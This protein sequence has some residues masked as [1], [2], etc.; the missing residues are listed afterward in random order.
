M[1]YTSFMDVSF[2]PSG[3]PG[4][5]D[6]ARRANVRLQALKMFGFYSQTPNSIAHPE[7]V[8]DGANSHVKAVISPTTTPVD[9]GYA[10]YA[11]M[12]AATPANGTR[13][14]CSDPDPLLR[15]R[16]QR[17]TGTWT[18]LGD[19]TDYLWADPNHENRLLNLIP[20]GSW[21]NSTPAFPLRGT[22]AIYPPPPS[23]DWRGVRLTFTVR[24]IDLAM[25]PWT[26][27]ALHC[28]GSVDARTA[29][30][31][32]VHPSGNY[33][34]PNFFQKTQLISDQLGFAQPGSWGQPNAVPSVKDT[35]WVDVVV[36]FSTDDLDWECLGRVQREYA[37]SPAYYGACPISELLQKLTGNIYWL[38]VYEKPQLDGGYW[39]SAQ[40]SEIT[41]AERLSGTIMLKRIRAE[42]LT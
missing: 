12:V 21:I 30:L 42:Y 37:A 39:G 18:R 24:A 28:Q 22:Q 38:A 10:T 27:L 3:Y 9:V 34:I 1:P 33:F 23:D 35:G 2:D 13:A 31:P 26:K 8:I 11:E 6:T 20:F 32:Q 5:D 17:A 4:A 7:L 40:A 25:G 19:L 15:G 16:Y 14:N 41:D 36:D 29:L